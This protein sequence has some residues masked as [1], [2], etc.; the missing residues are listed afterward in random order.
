MQ[1]LGFTCLLFLL[2]EV[3][4][5]R[6]YDF[7]HNPYDLM[8]TVEWMDEETLNQITP[9]LMKPHPNTYTYS[10][11]LTE[12]LVRDSYPQLPVCIVRPSI[13]KSRETETCSFSEIAFERSNSIFW[14]HM[15]LLLIYLVAE[16]VLVA[17]LKLDTTFVTNL[18][19]MINFWESLSAFIGKFVANMELIRIVYKHLA[20]RTRTFYFLRNLFNITFF[21]NNFHTS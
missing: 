9:N 12:C 13:G 3:L 15:Q 16:L 17:S 6:V 8:R 5:E 2:Q 1:Y 4:N 10:K 11:R 14:P 7:H 18:S 20:T 21:F 19:N